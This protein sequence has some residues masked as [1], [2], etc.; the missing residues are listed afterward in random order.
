MNTK[1]IPSVIAGAVVSAVILT[2]CKEASNEFKQ[3]CKQRGGK[4]VRE[5]DFEGEYLGMAPMAVSVPKPPPATKPAAPKA[6]KVDKLPKNSAPKPAK[7][8]APKTQAP[9][10]ND[11]AFGG[12]TKPKKNKKSKKD[13]NDFL[14][15]K[16]GEVL[17]EEDE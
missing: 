16:N 4:V 11:L 7:P 12:T 10:G 15:V 14:C 6:P 9:N 17:F 1:L 3:D 8:A 2:G 5:D 13:D